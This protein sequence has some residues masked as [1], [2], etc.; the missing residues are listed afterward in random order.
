M[1]KV[2][3]ILDNLYEKF[4]FR[5]L[6]SFIIPGA[7]LLFSVATFVA[8]FDNAIR[9]FKT[10]DFLF[11]VI[12]YGL[13][14]PLGYAVQTFGVFGWYFLSGKRSQ[15][16]R[17]HDDSR[18]PRDNQIFDNRMNRFSR[19]FDENPVVMRELE[20]QTSHLQMCGNI[21]I[22]LFL[23]SLFIIG[24][25]IFE[26]TSQSLVIVNYH[27]II[28]VVPAALFVVSLYFGHNI[29]IT[30]RRIWIENKLA[31]F[32]AP[33]TI[34]SSTTSAD[35]PENSKP[36]YNSHV[37][38]EQ[39]NEI[40]QTVARIKDYI[41]EDRALSPWKRLGDSWLGFVGL[42]IGVLGIAATIKTRESLISG[43]VL[44]SFGILLNW[45]VNVFI[46]GKRK[47]PQK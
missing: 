4:V 7:I 45:V 26:P 18:D 14:Y 35:K 34:P 31:S 21:S 24:R 11:Y 10:G 39:L 38:S 19:A 17:F 5:D 36:T 12:L 1:E 23:A 22:S 9:F 47:N 40:N 16:L 15:L 25:L 28:I 20:R 2:G 8:G 29:A 42:G 32:I 27:W 43:I 6:L 46:A 30:R 44:I 33:P 41:E 13:S 37:L 3:S